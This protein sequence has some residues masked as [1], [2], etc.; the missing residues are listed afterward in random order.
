MWALQF[1]ASAYSDKLNYKAMNIKRLLEVLLS[2]KKVVLLFIVLVIDATFALGQITIEMTP[3]G[4]VY[5][6]SGKVNGL[7]LN[8]K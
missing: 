5:S 8:F 7:E 2:L 4:N 1:H 6:L 3:K